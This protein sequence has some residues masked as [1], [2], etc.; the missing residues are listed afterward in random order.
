MLNNKNNSR[1]S[2]EQLT[3]RELIDISI[4]ELTEVSG[5]MLTISDRNLIKTDSQPRP[6]LK[7]DVVLQPTNDR[8]RR[9]AIDPTLC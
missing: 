4:K 7:T 8:F 2:I 1:I 9:C 5:G 3:H 6:L